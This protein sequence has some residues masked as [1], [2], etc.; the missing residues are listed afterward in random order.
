MMRQNFCALKSRNPVVLERRYKRESES[1]SKTSIYD[2]LTDLLVEQTI[3]SMKRDKLS[4]LRDFGTGGI[5]RTNTPNQP[6][7]MAYQPPP[8]PVFMQ[9]QYQL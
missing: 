7:Y 6:V 2:K 8:P 9:P 4:I 5:N 3:I 1:K